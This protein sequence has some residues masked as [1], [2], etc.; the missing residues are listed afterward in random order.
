MILDA[1]R[2]G[3]DYI[4]GHA[5]ADTLA[6][7]LSLDGRRLVTNGGTSTYALAALRAQ[8]RSTAGHATVEIDGGEFLRGLGE[9]SRR[10]SRQAA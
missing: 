2:V 10:P 1:A 6:F 7:E 5:H 8:E 3:P 4:P 9:L